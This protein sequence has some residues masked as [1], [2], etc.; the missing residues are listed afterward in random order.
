MSINQ[1]LLKFFSSDPDNF[2]YRDNDH[3]RKKFRINQTPE[4]IFPTIP[5]P[6][7]RPPQFITFFPKTQQSYDVKPH[8]RF[9]G[10]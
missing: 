3:D 10:S 4:N 7:T 9:T 8:L 2:F 5:G 1:I 6:Q